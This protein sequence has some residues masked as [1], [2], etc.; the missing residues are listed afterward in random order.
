MLQ[1]ELTPFVDLGVGWFFAP[2]TDWAMNSGGYPV[3]LLADAESSSPDVFFGPAAWDGREGPGKA[4]TLLS[5][6]NK[7]LDTYLSE[8]ESVPAPESA[9]PGTITVTEA[10]VL[11]GL[12]ILAGFEVVTFA[13]LMSLIQPILQ[14]KAEL[15]LSTTS[16]SDRL[17]ALHERWPEF[18][19]SSMRN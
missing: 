2:D 12:G 15:T 1:T 18:C 6:R 10:G 11:D 9:F 19:K 17:M 13:M 16:A 7:Y 14:R 4:R 3:A 5:V 8:D